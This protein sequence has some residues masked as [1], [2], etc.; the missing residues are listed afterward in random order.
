MTDKT[1]NPESAT[2]DEG[3]K[4]EEQFWDDFDAA[5]TGDEPDRSRT[6]PDDGTDG[7]DQAEGDDDPEISSEDDGKGDEGKTDGKDAEQLQS[8]I[9]RLQHAFESEKGRSAAFQ[10]QAAELKAQL[11]KAEKSAKGDQDETVKKRREKLAQAEEEYGDIIGPLAERVKE[12]DSRFDELN[13]RE[14]AELSRKREEYDRRIDEEEAAFRSEHPDEFKAIVDNR[15]TFNTWIED[16]PKRIR[17]AYRANF[18]EIVDGKGAALVVSLFKQA[19]LQADGSEAPAQTQ[20][21]QRLSSKRQRQLDGARSTKS[22]SPR[23]SS[24]PSAESDDPEA[25]WNYFDERDRRRAR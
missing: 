10:R 4:T 22:N 14:K 2:A 25:L 1:E 18:N 16:Q 24:S 20:T 7:D 11:A 19:L 15:D 9:E 23:S 8:Q 12:L 3:E 5:D 17:D 21:D 13:A 6:E